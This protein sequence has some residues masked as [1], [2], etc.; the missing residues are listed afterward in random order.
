MNQMETI[1]ME[2]ILQ[3]QIN[4]LAIN[5]PFKINIDKIGDIRNDTK[6]SSILE[7]NDSIKT[8]VE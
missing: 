6:D 2:Q 1:E 4:S 7:N 3:E 5:D 8:N